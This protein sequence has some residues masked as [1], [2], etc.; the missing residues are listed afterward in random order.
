MK[1]HRHQNPPDAFLLLFIE[2]KL[3]LRQIIFMDIDNSIMRCLGIGQINISVYQDEYLCATLNMYDKELFRVFSNNGVNHL[4]LL[5]TAKAFDDK[6]LLLKAGEMYPHPLAPLSKERKNP[7]F[8]L[9]KKGS[10][11]IFLTKDLVHVEQ[12]VATMQSLEAKPKPSFR[13]GLGAT[14]SEALDKIV[15]NTFSSTTCIPKDPM[16]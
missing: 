9:V 1:F 5:L 10:V 2:K 8:L 14:F 7:L 16:Q 13:S 3:G 12:Y 4:L 6:S 11:S 15:K